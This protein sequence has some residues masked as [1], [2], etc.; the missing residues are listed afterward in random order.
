MLYSEKFDRMVYLFYKTKEKPN[1]TITKHGG[2]VYVG[3]NEYDITYYCTW[4]AIHHEN[5]MYDN[6]IVCTIDSIDFFENI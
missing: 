3:D 2:K 5:V 1:N 4:A 6:T